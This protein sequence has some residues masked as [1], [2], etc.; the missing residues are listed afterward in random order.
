MMVLFTHKQLSEAGGPTLMQG[1]SIII[2]SSLLALMIHS[3]DGSL[4][5]LPFQQHLG[6]LAQ[7]NLSAVLSKQMPDPIQRIRLEIGGELRDCV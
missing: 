1:P 6:R 5:L 4:S 3:V 2:K 7:L